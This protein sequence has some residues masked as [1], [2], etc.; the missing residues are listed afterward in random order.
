MLGDLRA[1]VQSFP[2]AAYFVRG[3]LQ[4]ESGIP[5]AGFGFGD[6]RQDDL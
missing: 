3:D 5:S 6:H 2:K 1:I 4:A